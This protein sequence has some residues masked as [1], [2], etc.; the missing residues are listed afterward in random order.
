M[1]LAG[2]KKL[3]KLFQPGKLGK[4]TAFNRVKYGAC[5]I[6]NYNTRD[7]S[8]YRTR[9]G[10]HPGHRQNRLR[11]Y[12]PT[13]APIPTRSAR[14]KPISVKSPSMTINSCHEFEK[15]AGYIHDEGALAIQQILHCGRYGG[16]DLGYCVQPSVVPQTLPHFRP[17]REMTKEQIRNVHP[18]TCRRRE[19]CDQGRVRRHRAAQLHGLSDGQLQFQVHQQAHRRIWRLAGKPRPLHVR[20]DRRDQASDPGPPA[21]SC[22]STATISPTAGAV[23]RKTNVSS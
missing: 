16:I 11:H 15:I 22:A 8:Y 2:E 6:S 21:W 14:A 17:A 23:I 10:P 19:A 3:D 4:L 7:G 20:A 1:K 5:C 18:R 13:R 9:T 12:H